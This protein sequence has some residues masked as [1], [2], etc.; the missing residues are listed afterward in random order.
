MSGVV[1]EEVEE[2][3]A[4]STPQDMDHHEQR[5]DETWTVTLTPTSMTDSSLEENTMEENDNT[6]KPKS[7]HEIDNG[8][9]E[10][11]TK[12]GQYSPENPQTTEEVVKEEKEEEKK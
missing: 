3:T 2:K 1:E 8:K 5:H 10:Y 7:T 11:T 4:G 12:T 9:V 6:E